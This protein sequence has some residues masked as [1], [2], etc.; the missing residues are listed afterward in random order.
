MS[1]SIVLPAQISEDNSIPKMFGIQ[2]TDEFRPETSKNLGEVMSLVSEEDPSFV[3]DLLHSFESKVDFTDDPGVKIERFLA[4]LKQG[5]STGS[6]S[7]F[8]KRFGMLT[9]RELELEASETGDWKRFIK[10]TSINR[11]RG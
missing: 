2:S 4:F 3:R 1:D 6:I 9:K 10:R 11:I 7:E 8:A 5:M